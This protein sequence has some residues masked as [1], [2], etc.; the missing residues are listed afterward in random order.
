MITVGWQLCGGQMRGKADY[1]WGHELGNRGD[2]P[3]WPGCFQSWK[4]GFSAPVKSQAGTLP[5]FEIVGQR[6][7]ALKLNAGCA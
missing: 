7:S 2:C 5:S 3:K 4:A 6:M 1:G